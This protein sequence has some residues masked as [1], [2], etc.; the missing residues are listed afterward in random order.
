MVK[1]PLDLLAATVIVSIGL[2][3]A[4]GPRTPARPA[5]STAQCA[6]LSS[7]AWVIQSPPAAHAD[8]HHAPAIPGC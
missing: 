6:L 4:Y 2:L 5:V 7:L 3:A 1:R 8:R